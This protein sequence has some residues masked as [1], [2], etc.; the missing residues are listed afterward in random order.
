M[1][2]KTIIIIIIL[3]ITKIVIIILSQLLKYTQ[4]GSTS[5]VKWL[6]VRLQTK[7]LWVRNLVLSLKLQISRL[8]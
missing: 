8:F 2:I 4:H 1:V 7:W 3:V 5:L 6:S